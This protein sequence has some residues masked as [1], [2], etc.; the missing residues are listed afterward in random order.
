MRAYW[1][2][3]ACSASRPHH[4]QSGGSWF[5]ASKARDPAA[6]ARQH[7]SMAAWM[8]FVIFLMVSGLSKTA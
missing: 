7:G 6:P 4:H 8:G 5:A 3:G 2:S 1:V